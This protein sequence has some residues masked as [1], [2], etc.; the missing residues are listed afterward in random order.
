LFH[1]KIDLVRTR[2][3]D[4]L[5]DYMIGIEFQGWMRE[6]AVMREFTVRM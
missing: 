5:V 4:Y 3:K 1:D 6:L 2:V